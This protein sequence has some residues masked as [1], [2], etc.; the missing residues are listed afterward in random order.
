MHNMRDKNNT[1][2][3]L[4]LVTVIHQKKQKIQVKLFYIMNL[5]H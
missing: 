3:L 1:N 4:L 5:P 2:I